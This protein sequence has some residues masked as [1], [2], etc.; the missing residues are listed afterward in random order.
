MMDWRGSSPFLC[1]FDGIRSV[2]ILNEPI[3]DF[4][5]EL[6]IGESIVAIEAPSDIVPVFIKV[7]DVLSSCAA[8]ETTDLS[9]HGYLFCFTSKI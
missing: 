7:L 1:L 8:D 2:D 3:F 5:V 9:F 6:P 4:E